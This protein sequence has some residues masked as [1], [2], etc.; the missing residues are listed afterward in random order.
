MNRVIGVA[1]RR[2][3]LFL[4]R[5]G[6]PGGLI[7]RSDL[8]PGREI[9]P[10]D[11]GQEPRTVAPSEAREEEALGSPL[12]PAGGTNPETPD[13]RPSGPVLDFWPPELSENTCALFKPSERPFVTAATGHAC[14]C[15][16][17]SE[18]TEAAV[19]LGFKGH[20]SN[21]YVKNYTG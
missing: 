17:P 2:R 4:A 3:V 20:F 18:G 16:P 5:Q 10:C 6:P 11:A 21:P 12:E 13:L 19:G 14:S 9:T 7:L 8:D 15:P 1:L